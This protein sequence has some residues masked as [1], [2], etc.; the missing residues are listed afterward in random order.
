M[1]GWDKVDKAGRLMWCHEAKI[2]K[3]IRSNCRTWKNK[4]F[5]ICIHL[6]I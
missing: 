3:L 6:F 1:S 4:S 2:K 5:M